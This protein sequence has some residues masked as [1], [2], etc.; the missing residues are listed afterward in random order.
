MEIIMFSKKNIQYHKLYEDVAYEVAE[1]FR[2]KANEYTDVMF[3]MA[4]SQLQD[5]RRHL[6]IKYDEKGFY[7]IPEQKCDKCGHNLEN[8]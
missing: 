5:L 8:K 6:G 4:L 1:K 3:Q 7:L 2:I